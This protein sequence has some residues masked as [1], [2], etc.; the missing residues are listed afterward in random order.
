MFI[1]ATPYPVYEIYKALEPHFDLFPR[2]ESRW[3]LERYVVGLLA[4]IPRK[5]CQGIA[6]A[7]PGTSSQ[8]LQEL[9]TNTDWD[10][11]ALNT[12][13]VRHLSRA[14]ACEDGSIIIDDTGIPKQGKSS[15]GVARQYSG[16]L[17]KVGNCQVIVSL[18]YADE[19]DT[20]PVNARLYLPHEW[21]D[22]SERRRKVHVPDEVAFKTKADIALGMLDEADETGVPYQSVVFDAGYG[23]CQPFLEKLESR[24]KHYIGGIPNDFRVRLPE[25]VEAAAM[26]P[27]PPTKPRGTPRKKPYPNQLAPRR[28]ASDITASLPEDAWHTITW[29]QGSYG[30]LSKQFVFTRA[31]RASQKGTGPLGWLIHERPVPGQDGDSKWYFSNLGEDVAPE[32][33][34]ELAHRRHEIERFYQDAK[35]ELGFDHYEGRLWQGLHRHLILVMWAFSWLALRRNAQVE[36]MT[37]PCAPAYVPKRAGFFPL[38]AC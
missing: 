8:R 22:D 33:L 24:G 32:R 17:G 10:E 9:L 35:N 4:D 23:G 16:T 5:N 11:Q 1:K 21:A 20:W 18:Q 3:S 19:R 12:H 36:R 7:V 2:E 37:N 6:D 28:K 26:N 31:H 13:R 29:R 34:V 27:P 30:P 25:E 14:A 15:V 38:Q